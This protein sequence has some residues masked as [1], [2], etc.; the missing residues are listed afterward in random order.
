MKKLLLLTAG[1]AVIFCFTPAAAADCDKCGDVNGDGNVNILDVSAMI[2]FVYYWPPEVPECPCAAD[3]NCDNAVRVNCTYDPDPGY[4][5][6]D[7]EY[8][9]AYLYEEGP[10]PCDMDDDGTPD[11][12]PCN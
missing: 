9:I 12:D 1:I 6:D 3:V 7:I 2:K 11:C 10:P 5:C 4:E 8:L